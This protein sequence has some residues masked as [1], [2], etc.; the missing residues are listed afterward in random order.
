MPKHRIL[1]VEDEK[2]IA[3]LVYR[4]S[5]E[6]DFEVY[7]TQDCLEIYD[8]YDRCKPHIVVLDILMPNMDGFEVLNFLHKRNSKSRVVILSGQA[9]Y[10]PMASRMAEGLA[11]PIDATIAKPFRLNELRSTLKAIRQNLPEADA[12][13]KDVAA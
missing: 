5:I 2:D 8:L 7:T 11:L 13:S 9:H 4:V 10:R 1:I 12:L 3:D 6:S